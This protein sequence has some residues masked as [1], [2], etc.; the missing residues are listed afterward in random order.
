MNDKPLT[1]RELRRKLQE[2]ERLYG[3]I[4]EV[5]V[6]GAYASEGLIF[7]VRWDSKRVEIESD[8][9]SG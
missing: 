1:L 7:K 3:D 5:V 6:L 2:A 9:M 8:I 4:A